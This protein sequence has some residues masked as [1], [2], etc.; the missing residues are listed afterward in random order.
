[1]ANKSRG[2]KRMNNLLKKLKHK[3]AMLAKEKLC[4]QIDNRRARDK[5]NL[6][7]ELTRKIERLEKG[8][9]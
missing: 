1:M 9:L 2:I 5:I 4:N 8:G 6:I 3:R 7:S